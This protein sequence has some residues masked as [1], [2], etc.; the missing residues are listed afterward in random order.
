MLRIQQAA[1]VRGAALCP[2][3]AQKDKA[4][5]MAA[6]FHS[7][8]LRR[9]ANFHSTTLQEKTLHIL[10]A[11]TAGSLEEAERAECASGAAGGESGLGGGGASGG[12][13]GGKCGGGGSGSQALIERLRIQQEEIE[14]LAAVAEERN[15]LMRMQGMCVVRVCVSV[16]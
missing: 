10:S 2:S 11:V 6:N 3:A 7:T 4:H 1:Q 5:R 8:T 12:A 13:Q 14:R 15:E 16:L 9:A